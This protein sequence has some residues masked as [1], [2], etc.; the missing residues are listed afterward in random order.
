MTSVDALMVMACQGSSA[1]VWHVHGVVHVMIAM[2]KG[3]RPLISVIPSNINAHALLLYR[4]RIIGAALCV[5][6]PRLLL[7]AR[8]QRS[9]IKVHQ[10]H[11]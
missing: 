3:R 7:F 4:V 8:P 1:G 5:Y 11:K 2:N 10:P 6:Q 9:V